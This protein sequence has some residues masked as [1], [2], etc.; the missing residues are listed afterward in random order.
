MQSTVSLPLSNTQ[1]HS[2]I[3]MKPKVLQTGG[4][5]I[6]NQ[7]FSSQPHSLQVHSIGNI[8]NLPP[9]SILESKFLGKT[10]LPVSEEWTTA[11]TNSTSDMGTTWSSFSSTSRRSSLHS[12]SS[13]T[14]TFLSTFS[15][16]YGI[17]SS[18]FFFFSSKTFHVAYTTFLH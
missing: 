14:N 12:S 2:P 15:F 11:T 6:S 4:S 10:N 3:A 5:P 8:K 9:G 17:K 18:K 7:L 16:L 13:S 1:T